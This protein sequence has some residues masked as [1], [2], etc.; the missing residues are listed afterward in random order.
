[1]TN[2]DD[3]ADTAKETARDVRD[4]VS[5]SAEAKAE[6]ARDTVADHVDR[7]ADA[8]HSAAGAYDPNSIQAQLLDQLANNIEGLTDRLRGRSIEEMTHDAANFARRNP[9]LVL[10]GAAVAGFALAR[11]LKATPEA[12]RSA[13]SDPWTGHLNE[14]GLV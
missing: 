8:A 14:R 9:A 7:T 13:S 12:P 3:L 6:E 1:M 10:G 5:K 4:A 11:F 2:H